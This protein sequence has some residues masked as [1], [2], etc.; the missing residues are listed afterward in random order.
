LSGSG[1]TLEALRAHP[2]GLPFP[3]PEM[4]YRKYASGELR[5]DGKPGFETPSGKMEITSEWLRGH[6]YD[7]LPI[8]TEPTESP[9]SQPQL[10]RR[11]P[12]VFNSGA[13]TQNA[14][15]SQHLNV[16]SLVARQPYPLVHLHVSDAQT[17]GIQDGDD[18]YVVSPRGRVPF[19]ASVSTDILQ[20]VVEVSMGGGGPLGPQAWQQA[21]VNALTDFNNREAILGFPVYKALLCDVVKR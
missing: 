4:H 19:K 15:R 11:Y 2:E 8:Y 18:V 10:A 14:F 21:N 6:G 17:R 1:I 20:G 9:L 3:V 7:A 12:L 13:R 16:P 5:A